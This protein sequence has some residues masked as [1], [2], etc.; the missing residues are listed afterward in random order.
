MP[1]QP[2][3]TSFGLQNRDRSFKPASYTF[4]QPS[5]QSP[6]QKKARYEGTYLPTKALKKTRLHEGPF[7]A[8]TTPRDVRHHRAFITSA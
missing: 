1:A 3:P 8:R 4:H 5:K 6:S 2:A 7:T